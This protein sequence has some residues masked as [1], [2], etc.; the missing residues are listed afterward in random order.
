MGKV[1]SAA[2][3]GPQAQ[4]LAA[5]GEGRLVIQRCDGCAKHVF[6]PRVAC[7]AC[8]STALRW[9]EP[10]G[11][12]VVYSATT[13]RRPA[14][15]GGD[16]NISLVD[17]DEGVRLMSRVDGL[18]PDQVRIGMRVRARVEGRGA[19]ALLVFDAAG[20]GE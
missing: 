6:Y 17:L 16:Y 7:P 14:E 2:A 13:V 18:A 15:E 11:T 12:G 10:A 20:A 1:S 8:A 4:Y 5:L 9:T 19:E 3:G